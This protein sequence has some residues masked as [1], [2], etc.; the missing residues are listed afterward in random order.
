[1][2]SDVSLKQ[3]REEG[4]GGGRGGGGRQKIKQLWKKNF[5]LAVKVML[6]WLP[7]CLN[8]LAWCIFFTETWHHILIAPIHIKQMW[9][10]NHAVLKPLMKPCSGL[11]KQ[12]H[13]KKHKNIKR[14]TVLWNSELHYRGIT[15]LFLL[16]ALLSSTH[17][18]CL[19][20]NFI[21]LFSLFFLNIIFTPC[22]QWHKRTL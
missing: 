18:S 1:M 14:K 11:K 15:S 9:I 20:F 10:H 8:F 7:L 22:R 13:T 3:Y 21:F 2:T 6:Q 17:V 4:G 12:K 16:T 5:R 19:F